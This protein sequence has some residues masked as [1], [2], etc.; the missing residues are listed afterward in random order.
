MTVK[1]FWCGAANDKAADCC[2]SCRRKLEWSNF[3]NAILRP[4]VGCLLGHE[5]DHTSESIAAAGTPVAVG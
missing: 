5:Q 2:T 4:S 3:L 1:C